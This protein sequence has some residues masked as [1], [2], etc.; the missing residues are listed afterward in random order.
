MISSATIFSRRLPMLLTVALLLLA[1]PLRAEAHLNTTGLGPV[2]DGALHFLL[3]PE[4]LVPV[5]ALA[6]F[7][8]LRGA[9]HGRRAMFV[10]PA[11]WL[12]GGL[13]GLSVITSRGGTLTAISFLLLGG[14][15][16]ADARLSLQMLTAIAALLGFFHGYL[17]GAAM[18]QPVVGSIALLGLVSAV[19][20]L[21]TLAAAFVVRLRWHWTRIAVRVAGSWIAASG[22]LMLGW[23][24]RR[25]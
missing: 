21:V 24:M 3:S 22:L 17:N 5:L 14:L 7:A 19:F 16:A 8:G 9:A 10:L 20:V 11:A 23:A 25:G 2:Y 13:L 18:G 12:V 15:V 4:D 6:L 1:C